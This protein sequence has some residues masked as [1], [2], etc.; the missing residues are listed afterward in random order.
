MVKR[1]GTLGILDAQHR[2][3]KYEPLRFLRLCDSPL[4]NCIIHC[5]I[6]FFLLVIYQ[7]SN[8]LSNRIRDPGC[9]ESVSPE[10]FP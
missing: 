6:T 2:L 9:L 3:V 7:I 4:L 8:H 1:K 10:F 5:I